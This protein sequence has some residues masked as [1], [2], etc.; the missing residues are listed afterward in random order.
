MHNKSEGTNWVFTPACRF[1]FASQM[2][3]LVVFIGQWW[4]DMTTLSG[5]F[6]QIGPQ[7]RPIAH[8][9][10]VR[11]WDM[12]MRRIERVLATS[13]L[14]LAQTRFWSWP[15]GKNTGILHGPRH[16]DWA[17]THR[18]LATSPWPSVRNTG[19]LRS[20][21]VFWARGRGR[22]LW[23]HLCLSSYGVRG[24]RT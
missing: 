18:V 12:T 3:H 20:F 19:I 8:L 23:P 13:P 7:G 21:A 24:K 16:D 5:N 11:T 1:E 10:T 14:V 17:K 2:C 6:Y 9:R 22:D 15:C 4:P